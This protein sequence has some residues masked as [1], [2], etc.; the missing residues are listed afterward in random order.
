MEPMVP[1][2]RFSLSACWFNLLAWL[3]CKVYFSS[4]RIVGAPLRRRT[5]Q[6]I[7]CSHR[8]GAIDGCC[9]K[10]AFPRALFPLSVQLLRNAL[11][12][13]MFTGIP[14][15]RP[16][17]RERYGESVAG[18]GSVIRAACAHLRAGGALAMFPEGSSEWGP[19]PLPYHSGTARI[20]RILLDEGVPLEVTPLGL[21]Y[22]APDRFRSGVEILLGE[23]VALPARQGA[24]PR[25]WERQIHAALSQ[26]LD[27]VSVNCPDVA[28]FERVERLARADARRGQSYALAFKHWERQAAQGLPSDAPAPRGT[29][30]WRWLCGLPGMA[31]LAPVLLIGFLAG[32]KADAR[33][34][35]TF[36]RI[37]GGFAAALLWLPAL[38]VLFGFFPL[39]MLCWSA[40]AAAGWPAFKR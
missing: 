29:P 28:S 24:D 5:H 34:T 33:N 30:L 19:R 40:L 9:V 36:F 37:V 23:P 13:L 6:L 1:P 31:L 21:F 22:H 11:L 32:R 25:E 35:V 27:T 18:H 12:R 4:V 14:V 38:A 2:R 20:V 15:V 7:V 10:L 26:A 8:N 17:D 16:K 39:P 3:L